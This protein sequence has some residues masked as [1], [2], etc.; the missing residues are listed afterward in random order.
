MRIAVRLKPR[1]GADRLDG[2][3]RAAD[4]SMA[5]AASVIAPPADG[6]ANDALLR[7]LARAL[8]LPRR[9]LTIIGGLKSRSKVVHVAGDPEQM[10][11]RLAAV[12]AALP[13]P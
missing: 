11:A 3:A 12:L 10:M 4:G 7:L 1:A 8:G 9:S 5:L 6:R 2:I 13:R